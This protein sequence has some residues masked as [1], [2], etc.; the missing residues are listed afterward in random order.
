M[1]HAVRF[2]G[3]PRDGEVL[4]VASL[5][6]TFVVKVS[7]VVTYL[8]APGGPREPIV[9]YRDE[10]YHLYKAPGYPAPCRRFP[11]LYVH[12]DEATA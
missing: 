10:T 3:G 7:E 11:A 8:Q 5:D 9:D 12:A 2:I 6:P 4:D 1:S